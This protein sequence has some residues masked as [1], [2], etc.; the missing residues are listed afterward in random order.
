M[1][2]IP[3]LRSQAKAGIVNINPDQDG[4]TRKITAKFVA[5]DTSVYNHFAV[6]I[7]KTYYENKGVSLKKL[8]EIPQHDQFIKVN[9]AA[10]PESFKRFSFSEV[11]DGSVVPANFTDKIVLIGATAPDL[12]DEQ[13]TPLSNGVQMP[14]VEIHAN[15]IQT[16][17]EEKY[18]FPE[19]DEAA[20]VTM[21]AVV[22]I[23]TAVL[24]FLPILPAIVI[25][26]ITIVAYILYCIFSFDNGVVRNIVVPPLAIFATGTA[27]IVYKY[28]VE[29]RQK[30]FI[31]KA[32]S[33][34]LSSDVLSEILSSPKK[35]KLGGQ[36]AEITVLFSDIAGF[37]SISE[38][39]APEKLVSILNSYLTRMTKIVFDN[40]GVLDKYIGDAVMAFWGAPL[41]TRNH[42]LLAC[43][44]ALEMYQEMAEVRREWNE[45][46]VKDFDIRIGV[47]SGEMAVGNMGSD[48][49][50]DYT[51]LGDNVNLG[52]RLEG[53]N[54]EYKTKIIISENTYKQVRDNVVARKLDKVAVKGKTAGVTIYELRG[55]SPASA[56]EKEFL[57]DF[58]NANLDTRS[59]LS[60]RFQKNTPTTTQ[61]KCTSKD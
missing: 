20:A 14:G 15:A 38:K 36:R 22:I 4:V 3:A 31:K 34:Y 43:K 55:F 59:R 52:S 1:L 42:A 46:G 47:N 32:F 2:P 17:L 27:N 28:F 10:P 60:P 11:L 26:L 18:L 56:K 57:K 40:R 53:I 39:I 37:T 5:E 8:N 49:R 61:R 7:L 58:E 12:H 41:P 44:T 35:L 24:I 13:L 51:L 54:K 50:F 9:Y 19:T 16:I 33:Y 21:T 23:L 6:E 45:Y 29:S 30:R 25:S 48:M